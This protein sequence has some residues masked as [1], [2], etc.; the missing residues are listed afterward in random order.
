MQGRLGLEVLRQGLDMVGLEDKLWDW[1]SK[2][3]VTRRGE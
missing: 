2:H 3:C 1:C